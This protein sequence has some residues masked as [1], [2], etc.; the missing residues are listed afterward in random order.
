MGT[1][2]N[3]T[4]VIV[5]VVATATHSPARC[6]GDLLRLLVIPLEDGV[7]V[8]AAQSR[9]GAREHKR[10][11]E[12]PGVGV[13]L[14]SDHQVSV[15]TTFTLGRCTTIEENKIIYQLIQVKK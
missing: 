4:G 6:R 13:S 11:L 2:D 5:A 1:I 3:K 10:G 9:E 8:R 7:D 15:S 12:G 14:R